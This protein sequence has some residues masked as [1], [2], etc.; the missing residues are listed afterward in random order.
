MKM[1]ESPSVLFTIEKFKPKDSNNSIGNSRSAFND[2]E[3]NNFK[4]SKIAV[5]IIKGHLKE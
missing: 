4:L 3:F 5:P 1:D 2:S